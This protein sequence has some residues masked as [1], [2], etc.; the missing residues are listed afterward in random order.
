MRREEIYRFKNF[1]NSSIPE[2]LWEYI[3][4]PIHFYRFYKTD[5][6]SDG[7]NIVAASEQGDKMHF[8]NSLTPNI[9][10]LSSNTQEIDEDLIWEEAEHAQNYSVYKYHKVITEIN[11]SVILLQEGVTNNTYSISS[12][13]NGTYY[14]KIAA[15]NK[16]GK[17]Y[18]NCL[19]INVLLYPPSNFN[20]YIPRNSFDDDGEILFIWENST[21]ANN[22]SLFISNNSETRCNGSLTKMAEGIVSN[23]YQISGLKSGIYY[24]KVIAYN[25]FGSTSS[26]CIE[27]QV[28]LPQTGISV[29][30][31]NLIS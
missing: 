10:T 3:T 24:F 30:V 29:P 31:F 22:Y 28:E 13:T 17:S 23:F 20:I 1:F 9:F 15:F 4:D 6:S 14:F 19:K 16:H 21:Y 7:K 11:E 27:I 18:S 12:L 5:I 2:P 8:F 26:N 25:P